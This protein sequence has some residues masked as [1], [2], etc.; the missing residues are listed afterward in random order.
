[1]N[2]IL[3]MVGIG[4]TIFAILTIYFGNKKI[5]KR[6]KMLDT[7]EI[8]LLEMK[9]TIEELDNKVKNSSMEKMKELKEILKE[10]DKKN[11][12]L[13]NKIKEGYGLNGILERN[14]DKISEIKVDAPKTSFNFEEKSKVVE[15]KQITK[16]EIMD[17]Y[18]EGKDLKEISEITGK[19]LEDIAVIM[20]I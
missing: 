11:L 15:K 19:T 6:A 10:V 13:D 9:R 18:K 4:I 3:T 1:M 7:Y 8:A 16:D 20:G 2:L 12:I 5:D 17:L 14:F